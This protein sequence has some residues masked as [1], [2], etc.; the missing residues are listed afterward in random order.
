MG[1]SRSPMRVPAGFVLGSGGL[2]VGSS[3]SPIQCKVDSRWPPG[4]FRHV[5]WGF[6]VDSE[7][8]GLQVAAI[9]TP[10]KKAVRAQQ[11]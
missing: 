4:G 5:V 6:G 10:P 3:R 8:G 9:P 7:G 11:H 2:C 1:S